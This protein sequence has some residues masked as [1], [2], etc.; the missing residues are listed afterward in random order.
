[1]HNAV[2]SAKRTLLVAVTARHVAE[3]VVESLSPF[4]ETHYCYL[5]FD[6][7]VKLPWK[8][9]GIGASCQ[10][11]RKTLRK[12]L[13]HGV[14]E[15]NPRDWRTASVSVPQSA[16]PEGTVD[17]LKRLL[18]QFFKQF[19][20]DVP[21]GDRGRASGGRSS[22]RCSCSERHDRLNHL[23]RLRPSIFGLR[24]VPSFLDHVPRDFPPET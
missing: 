22:T 7:P 15:Q 12:G 8:W 6:N 16:I 24:T 20:L 17:E 1:M 13:S 3:K 2:H 9:A 19:H 23:Q 18:T 5:V 4:L 14:H 10:A 11:P 21:W